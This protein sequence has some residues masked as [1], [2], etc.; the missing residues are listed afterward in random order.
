M[1]GEERCGERSNAIT[2]TARSARKRRQTISVNLLSEDAEDGDGR[3]VYGWLLLTRQ[4]PR[5]QRSGR[6]QDADTL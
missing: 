3:T 1:T 6:M 2:K 4:L 5:I